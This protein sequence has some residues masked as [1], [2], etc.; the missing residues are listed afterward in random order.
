MDNPMKSSPYDPVESELAKIIFDKLEKIGLKPKFEGFSQSRPNVV[1]EFGNKG[2]K[3]IFNGHMDTVPPANGYSYP[4]FSGA[5]RE[6]KLYGVGALDMKAALCAFIYMARALAEHKKDLRGKICLQFVI[7]EEPMAASHFGT[8]FLLDRGYGGDAAIVGEPGSKKI[9]VGNRG[10]YRFKIETFGD[11]VHTGSR[12]WEKK[13]EGKNA[14][15]DMAKAINAL[16]KIEFPGS[17]HPL[18]PGRKN[19]FTFP[20]IINGGKSINVVPDRCVAFGDVRIMPGIT[21]EIVESRIKKVLNALGITYKLTPVIYVPATF[22]NEK[23]KI[24]DVIK[25]NTQEVLGFLPYAEGS[26]PWSDMWMFNEKGIPAINFG[27]DGNGIHD[28]DEYVDIQNMVDVTKIYAL[29]AL[30]F[31]K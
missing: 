16:Q 7:D 27:P 22:I 8:R 5:V 28:K 17:K 14:I 30:D 18:F 13:Q 21:Q 11:A 9:T 3:L 6:G 29:T 2:K 15:L 10:G 25:K 31:L 23:E 4:P 19:V 12:E 26:G 24:V 20:T 1:C